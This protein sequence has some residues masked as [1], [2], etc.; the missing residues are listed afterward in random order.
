M[1]DSTRVTGRRT[2]HFDSY[3][4]LLADVHQMNAQPSRY[5]GN[6]SLGQVCEHLAKAIEYMVDGAP[7]RAPWVIR[8]VGPWIKK[9]IISRPMKPGFRLPKSAAAYL[10]ENS[11][12]AVGIARLEQAIERYRQAAVLKPHSIFGTMTREEVDQL[13]FRHAE[14]HLSFIVPE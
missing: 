7:F 13:N 10:P 8:T 3:E 2:V 12:A 4:E 9:R 14:M 6:W 5:L 1:V 11:D